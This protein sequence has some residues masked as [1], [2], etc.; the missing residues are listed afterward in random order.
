M[1]GIANL[2]RR[3]I[4]LIALTLAVVLGVAILALVAMKPVYTASSLVMV[5][6]SRKNLLEAEYAATAPSA[7]NARVDSEVEILRSNAVLL[8]VIVNENLIDD[9]EFGVSE[10]GRSIGDFFRAL[11][12]NNSTQRIDDPLQQVLR[13]FTDAVRVQ[14]RGLTYLITHGY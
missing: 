6:T 12:P 1:R 4:R 14:R 9:A 7:D 13:K 10:G 2:L 5:D 11:L 3:R 8:S